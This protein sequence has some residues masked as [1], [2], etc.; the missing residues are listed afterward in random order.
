[1]SIA[2]MHACTSPAP[3]PASGEECGS[4]GERVGQHIRNFDQALTQIRVDNKAALGSQLGQRGE[5]LAR[6]RLTLDGHVNTD[7]D[8][9]T[10]ERPRRRNRALQGGASGSCRD[11]RHIMIDQPRQQHLQKRA[12]ASGSKQQQDN[13]H[14]H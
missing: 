9:I 6:E 10:D 5:A 14:A 2:Q 4:R 7:W 8:A 3:A 11:K 1:M 12:L 13:R